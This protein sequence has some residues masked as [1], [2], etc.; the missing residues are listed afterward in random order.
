[1]SRPY[2]SQMVESTSSVIGAAPR[3]APAAKARPAA[4]VAEV[5]VLV[6]ELAEAEPLSQG[7][8][9]EQA[10]VGDQAVVIEGDV[11]V[12]EGVRRCHPESAP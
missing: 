10:G 5:H 9:Q 2:V 1:M 7:A 6:E 11:E 3:P 8:G 4:P 12:V